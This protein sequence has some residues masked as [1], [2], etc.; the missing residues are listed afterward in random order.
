MVLLREC[1]RVYHGELL[2]NALRLGLFVGNHF[3]HF[4]LDLKMS[5]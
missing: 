2:V 5:A 3:L 4:R 1:Y